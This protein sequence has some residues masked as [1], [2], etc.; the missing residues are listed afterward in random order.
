VTV[1]NLLTIIGAKISIHTLRVE[2][3][4]WLTN[5]MPA[6]EFQ[7][8]PSGWR[9]T[10]KPKDYVMSEVIS[11]HTLRVEGDPAWSLFVCT[12]FAFQSTPSGWRVT[13]YF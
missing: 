12:F 3:D 7:S 13:N 4:S 9:V 10:G 5:K 2:G 11:I 8:T 1:D 6:V